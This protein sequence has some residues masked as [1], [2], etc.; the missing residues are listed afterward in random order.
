LP[1]FHD[2]ELLLPPRFLP[3]VSNTIT[4]QG[5]PVLSLKPLIKA[6]YLN[7][8]GNRV[9]EAFD[10]LLPLGLCRGKS[11]FLVTNFIRQEAL[12]SFKLPVQTLGSRYLLKGMP[13]PGLG[14]WLNSDVAL[15]GADV[16]EY[17]LVAY[18]DTERFEVPLVSS[19]ISSFT[20]LCYLPS[21]PTDI[22]G[23]ESIDEFKVLLHTSPEDVLVSE[24]QLNFKVIDQGLCGSFVLGLINQYG[25][26]ETL[27]FTAEIR[28]ETL[29]SGLI[30][31]SISTVF[32]PS[33]DMVSWLMAIESAS[34]LFEV[35]HS[36]NSFSYIPIKIH[37]TAI[38]FDS[39]LLNAAL[40]LKI[41][42]YGTN[43]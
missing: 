31:K 2:L 43:L 1:K 30:C 5:N 10:N 28:F 32:L 36:N 17:F 25:I 13:T 11:G 20:G 34:E 6:S 8:Q 40:T 24:D 33:L 4:V 22:S 41:S 35:R 37:S 18:T 9:S 15:Y 38:D 39:D 16:L 19:S 26:L 27:A 23:Y 7:E 42:E 21:L 29:S 12:G 3:G 14:L